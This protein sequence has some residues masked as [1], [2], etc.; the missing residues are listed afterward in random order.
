MQ[1]TVWG[2]QG[3]CGGCRGAVWGIWGMQGTVWG[4]WGVRM[5][6]GE[7]TDGWHVRTGMEGQ[8][9]NWP[10]WGL[11]RQSCSLGRDRAGA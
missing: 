10:G 4:T 5:R 9:G 6:L 3:E 8:G 11:E 7:H 2:V 1:G